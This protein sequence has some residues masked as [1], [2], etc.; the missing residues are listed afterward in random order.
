MS[1][2]N[3][4]RMNSSKLYK[5]SQLLI[6][7]N[8]RTKP[9]L[10]LFFG[11]EGTTDSL[12]EDVNYIHFSPN[13]PKKIWFPDYKLNVANLKTS[14]D[15]T[16][17][18]S[19]FN[20]LK[21]HKLSFNKVNNLATI[22][23]KWAKKPII[24]DLS[25]F[26]DEYNQYCNDH[27]KTYTTGY[28]FLKAMLQLVLKNLPTGMETRFFIEIPS[29]QDTFIKSLKYGLDHDYKALHPILKDY[30]VIFYNPNTGIVYKTDFNNPQMKARGNILIGKFMRM[31]TTGLPDDAILANDPDIEVTTDANTP[32]ED[33]K[34][35]AATQDVVRDE[36]DKD[37]NG[38]SEEVETT[39]PAKPTEPLDDE[40]DESE[41]VQ[42]DQVAPAEEEQQAPLDLSMILSTAETEINTLYAENQ[43]FLKKH[44]PKQEAAL[45]ELEKEADKLAADK[46]LDPL[47]IN[48]K[49][50][51]NDHVRETTMSSITNGYYK[52]QFKRDVLNIVKTLNTDP[53]NPVVITKFAVNDSSTAIS[54]LDELHIEFIDKKFKK[55]TFKVD[56]PRL[57]HD[58]F[59]YINGNKQFISKQA[60][61][62]PIIKEAD[63]RVQ[64]TTNYQKTFLF[65]KGDKINGQVD[66]ILRLI[67]GT[68][69]DSIS[70]IPGNSTESNLGYNV[71]IPYNY[72]AKKLFT[73]KFNGA[74]GIIFFF[75]QQNAR[76][77]AEEAGFK[78]DY[79]KYNVVGAYLLHDK[80][81][82][83][84]LEDINDRS[85][86][87]YYRPNQRN[88]NSGKIVKLDT[89]IVGFLTSIISV[90]K[91]ES[92]Q[93]AYRALKPSL[94]LSFTEVKIAAKA[95]GLGPLIASFKGLIPALDLYHV[96]YHIEEKRIAK[97]ES[98][99]ML[100]FKDYY[101][102][103]DTEFDSAKELYVNSL[104]A[105]NSA[106]YTL[107]ETTRMS[108]IFLEYYEE[109]TGNRNTAKALLNFESSMIDPITKEILEEMKLPTDFPELL[110]VANTMLGDY[111]R[112]LKN[113]MSNF[114]FRDSEVIATAV[115]NVLRDSFNAYKRTV[116]SGT[117]QPISAKK[118]EVIKRIQSMPNVEPYSTLNPFLELETKAKSTFKGPSGL[119]PTYP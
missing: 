53:E 52:K 100:A 77:K 5:A 45:K 66:R 96:K 31:H 36:S 15:L 26:R 21:S 19:F 54:R 14:R 28:R 87:Q 114:R 1:V 63:D 13:A 89:S 83:L 67:V 86:W 90:S 7:N 82:D 44:M 43:A 51:I 112:K 72:L 95:M 119:N 80:E 27:K 71:S 116:R 106:D 30:N 37:Q 39:I 105:L 118:D 56:V 70:K 4:A 50:I 74:E 104:L 61:L 42:P 16:V 73:A 110:L 60:T 20:D 2:I 76:E 103:I 98:E 64:I 22:D 35:V 79:T 6:V 117:V 69:F 94:S 108:P 65:R 25:K 46:T 9:V 29:E 81:Q 55:H 49:T 23:D 58:G 101:L 48:D 88:V 47:V 93:T 115:Y 91:D 75:N 38:D 107:A 40:S 24:V 85:I 99:I 17:R 111:Q 62:L 34:I 84:I 41:E 109:Y 10:N 97:K 8:S 57:S 113:D 33:K 68:K 18:N 3:L 102:Y 32:T 59:L 92:L 12:V 78:V 11:K